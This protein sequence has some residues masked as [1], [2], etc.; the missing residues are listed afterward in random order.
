MFVTLYA[1]EICWG[2]DQMV[3]EKDLVSEAGEASYAS[4]TVLTCPLPLDHPTP[5]DYQVKAAMWAV[6]HDSSL[7]NNQLSPFNGF[8]KI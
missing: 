2:L 7:N 1:S 3:E 6:D 8:L 5:S 4:V